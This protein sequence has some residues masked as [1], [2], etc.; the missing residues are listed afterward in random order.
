MPEQAD[1]LNIYTCNRPEELPAIAAQILDQFVGNRVVLFYG[2][3][4]AGK[5]TLINALCAQLKVLDAT[6]SP[7]YSIVNEYLTNEGETIYHFDFYRIKN[8]FE[9]LDIGIEEYFDSGHYCFIEWPEK[10]KNYLP[11]EALSV[12]I[13]V[14]GEKRIFS[15]GATTRPFKN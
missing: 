4:G 6:S 7:T 15:I 14:Q 3:M 2:E 1:L 8:E 13:E 12:H 5:T 9:A 11:S 10:I